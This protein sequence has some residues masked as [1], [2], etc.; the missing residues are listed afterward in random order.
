MG[1]HY[2]FSDIHGNYKLFKKIKGFL[3]QD[4]VCYV[5]G[6]CADRGTKG[7]TIIKEVLQ[8]GRFIYI[9]GNHEDLFATSILTQD[10]SYI[11]CWFQ[12]GGF[13]TFQ[14]FKKDNPSIEL[15]EKINSLPVKAVYTSLKGITYIMTHAGFRYSASE[16]ERD[17]LWDRTH[18]NYDEHIPKDTVLIHG[19]T[20]ARYLMGAGIKGEYL[21]CE[22]CNG[23]SAAYSYNNGH[24]IDID[25]G[26]AM[27]KFI[28]LYNL[29]NNKV[30]G[31]KE[32]GEANDKI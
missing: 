32:G 4:D 28:V 29:D 10:T 19:H 13:P 31:F 25:C 12:N 18:F 8:D 27:S 1:S 6:D 22:N 7:Y 30:Y 17:Y 20:S 14:E 23:R 9:K 3:H 2:V 21:K 5:L 16:E 24:K 11:E 15:I 26:T